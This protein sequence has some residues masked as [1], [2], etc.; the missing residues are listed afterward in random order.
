MS[1]KLNKSIRQ[2]HFFAKGKCRNGAACKFA[3]PASEKKEKPKEANPSLIEWKTAV[4]RSMQRRI[5]EFNLESK[6]IRDIELA[7]QRMEGRM[8]VINGIKQQEERRIL[9]SSSRG[10]GWRRKCQILRET[11]RSLMSDSL[12]LLIAKYCEVEEMDKF[13]WTP[14]YADR[15]FAPLHNRC[16]QCGFQEEFDRC[17]WLNII[18]KNN[19]PCASVSDMSY[20]VICSG[21]VPLSCNHRFAVESDQLINIDDDQEP[22]VDWS[23]SM[24]IAWD[25]QSNLIPTNNIAR[26]RFACISKDS[27]LVHLSEIDPM[28]PLNL[29]FG[30]TPAL[31]LN[32][33]NK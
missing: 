2:C 33:E 6:K 15:V 31:V 7:K 21:C 27:V 32:F 17:L 4:E 24:K 14:G 1:K 12:L 22:D 26:L 25:E 20:L 8:I 30:W 5:E 13:N 18:L 28:K 29:Q 19:I 16:M 23:K 9:R 10:P 11:L 3:H